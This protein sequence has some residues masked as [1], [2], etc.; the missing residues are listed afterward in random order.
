[1]TSVFSAWNKGR[2]KWQQKVFVVGDIQRASGAKLG[3]GFKGLLEE[4]ERFIVRYYT[5]KP[6]SD[7]GIRYGLET[8]NGVSGYVK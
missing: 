8:R 4:A 3:R 2:Y 7:V 1:L 5:T 6:P